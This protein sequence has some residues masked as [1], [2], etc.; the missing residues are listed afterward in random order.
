MAAAPGVAPRAV[1]AKVAA[2]SLMGAPRVRVKEVPVRWA[3]QAGH[4]HSGLTP[5]VPQAAPEAMAR[6]LA[7][8]G[9]ARAK[10]QDHQGPVARARS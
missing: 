7:Q 6:E 1:A 3:Q 4:P 10:E 5:K 9:R 8:T 2:L